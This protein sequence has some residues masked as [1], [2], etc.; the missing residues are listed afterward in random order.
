MKTA[1]I[2]L[3]ILFAYCFYLDSISWQNVP[4]KVVKDSATWKRNDKLIIHLTKK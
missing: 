1:L 2:L 3:F 4:Y